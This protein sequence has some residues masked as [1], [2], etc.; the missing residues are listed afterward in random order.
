MKK[1]LIAVLSAGVLAASCTKEAPEVLPEVS[2]SSDETEYLSDFAVILSRA[3]VE[4][5]ALRDFIKGEALSEFD[6]DYDVFYAWTKDKEVSGG[7]TFGEIVSQYDYEGRL[8]EILAA[9]P[10]LT[11]LVPDWSWINENCFCYNK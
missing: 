8:P 6:N 2:D 5:P 4:E 9:V 3:V 1:I 7:K 10:T 11:V